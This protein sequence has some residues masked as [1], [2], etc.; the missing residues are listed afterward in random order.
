M[1]IIHRLMALGRILK[2]RQKLKKS[3]YDNWRQY[4][5]NHDPDIDRYANY[6]H[7]FYKG[8]P[9]VYVIKD[10]NHYAYQLVR[11]YG[12]A[13]VVYGYDVMTNWC[14][15]K[16]RWNYRR[17]IHRIIVN[18]SGLVEFNDL[19][20]SDYIYFAFKNEKDFAHFL[21]RWS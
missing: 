9:Y 19:G 15:E 1:K 13:G 18:A 16:I 11:D 14:E 2:S 3:G 21:L 4:K 20:G 5:H 7:Q 17:D 10:Y 8:Y 6:V 12:I